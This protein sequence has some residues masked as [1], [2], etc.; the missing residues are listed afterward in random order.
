MTKNLFIACLALALAFSSATSFA[1]EEN[2]EPIA[3]H[4]P[5]WVSTTGYWVAESNINTPKHNTLYFYNNDD[6]LV[7][8]E[9]MDGVVLKLNKRR[10]KMRLKK[11]VDQTV[12]AY[13][14]KQT[15]AENEMLVA[16]LIK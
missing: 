1:Q 2:T 14:Q 7:Y 4:T 13:A 8:K 3:H 15:A 6:V 12:T 5:K 11:L 9:T 16:K 10:I